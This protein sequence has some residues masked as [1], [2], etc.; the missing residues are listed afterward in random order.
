MLC[1]QLCK[2]PGSVWILV[3]FWSSWQRHWASDSAPVKSYFHAVKNCCLHSSYLLW[4]RTFARCTCQLMLKHICVCRHAR[5]LTVMSDPNQH[6]HTWKQICQTA[7]NRTTA[8]QLIG[9]GDVATIST[10][11]C[12]YTVLIYLGICLGVWP[13]LRTY[14]TLFMNSN[15][16]KQIYKISLN[17]VNST[18]FLSTH[19]GHRW[20]RASSTLLLGLQKSTIREKDPHCQQAGMGLTGC[21]T[22]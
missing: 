8:R 5:K 11:C 9:T 17:P 15:V 16:E 6:T 3:P 22:R 1:N 2:L 10:M 7:F 19:F 21:K 14:S 13:S 12:W 18:P 4:V 20:C